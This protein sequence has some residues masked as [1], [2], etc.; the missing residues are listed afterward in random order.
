MTKYRFTPQTYRGLA[1]ASLAALALVTGCESEE[2]KQPAAKAPPKPAAQR[3]YG[4]ATP[5]GAPAAPAVNPEKVLAS[6][7]PL[8]QPLEAEA[9]N[10]ANPWTKQ[11]ADLGRMLYYENRLSK[12]HDMSCNTCH[13]LANYGVDVREVDGKRAKTS[14]GHKKAFGER[15]SPT[16][17][18]AAFH[19][20]QFWDGR[21]ADVEEQAKGPILNPVEMAMPDEAKVVATLKSMQ[22]YVDAFKAA[23]PGDADPITYDNM[24]KAIGAFER[25]LVTPS[26]F[27]TFI[28]GDASALSDTEAAGLKT[29]M[30]VGCTQCHSG[31]LLGGNQ[32]Q[33]LGNVKPWPDAK[34]E[35]RFQV[36]KSAPDKF[37]FKVPSLRNITETG[38]YLHDG[39]IES[40][41]EMVKKMAEHQLA[42]G[43]LTDEETASIMTFLGTL[44]GDVDQDYIKKPTL[45]ESG[46]DT[47]A[48][49]AS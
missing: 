27:D 44:K 19:L 28:A 33:K 10:D 13:D 30:D 46:P 21:A 39:S 22:G 3:T 7:K 20:A 1:L 15:N 11:K 12:N 18:N 42:K 8:F 48:P 14:E 36:T 43:S 38:P 41:E 32:F 26:K 45:P 24:A 29:F 37:S 31:A 35:G 34:D 25:K 49:D 2:N 16:V 5:D 47:P 4:E 40:L 23:F 6:A 9:K 17:Y